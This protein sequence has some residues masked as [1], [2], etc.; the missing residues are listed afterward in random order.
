MT[1]FLFD[2]KNVI[3]YAFYEENDMNKKTVILDID[4]TL[5]NFREPACKLFK[6]K[7]G[8]DIPWKQWNCYRLDKI[9]NIPVNDLLN[10]VIY[11]N[12]LEKLKLHD[13]SKKLVNRLYEKDFN[14]K[15]ISSRN[16]HPHAFDVTEEWLKKNKIP[17]NSL[18]ISGNGIK[19]SSFVEKDEN[20]VLAVDDNI[21]NCVDFIKNGKVKN[22]HL[23]TMPWNRHSD[24]NRFHNINEI[25]QHM[26]L[27]KENEIC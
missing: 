18:H 11:G 7:T 1:A 21:D 14:I 9:Y 16:Y 12:M 24:M 6:E 5:A 22:P 13:G 26:Y 23:Y 10:Y 15:I 25:E 4:D 20:V 27:E 3:R 2:M 8:K 17:F 19:K